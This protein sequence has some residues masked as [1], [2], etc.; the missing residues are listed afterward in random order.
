MKPQQGTEQYAFDKSPRCTA[1]SNAR[2][3]DARLLPCGDGTYAAST[4]R[5][6]V[7]PKAV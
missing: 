2:A 5:E 6:V 4:V 1:T 7:H 3:S